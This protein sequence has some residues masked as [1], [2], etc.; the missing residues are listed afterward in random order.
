[1]IKRKSSLISLIF[2]YVLL[3]LSFYFVF[4]YVL[5]NNSVDLVIAFSFSFLLFFIYFYTSNYIHTSLLAMTK[6]IWT[7][8][9][10]LLLLLLVVRRFVL[11]LHKIYLQFIEYKTYI[12]YNVDYSLDLI[13]FDLIQELSNKYLLNNILKQFYNKMV[14]INNANILLDSKSIFSDDELDL[15]LYIIY[16]FYLFLD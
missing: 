15:N 2:V 11:N 16:T 3:Y 1:M 12:L 9:N 14:I 8:F 5:G 4:F 13:Y 6:F 10:A 7:N